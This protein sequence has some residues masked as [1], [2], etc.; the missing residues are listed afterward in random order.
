MTPPRITVILAVWN[1]AA[2]LTRALQSVWEQTYPAVEVVV[3]D[4][5]SA[6][7]TADILRAHTDKI[8]CWESAPDR[9][10]YHAW[11]KALARA[12][13]D[14]I[15]FLGAD[16]RLWSPDALARLAAALPADPTI[17]GPR[18]VYGQA[19]IVGPS[20]T[21]ARLDGRPW[22]QVKRGLPWTLTLPHPG[23]L[24]HRT[25]F[26]ERGLFD[27]TFRIVGDY[28]LLLREL[29]PAGGREALFVPDVVTVG[30]AH[31]GVSHSPRAMASMLAE[32]AR[33]R[34]KHVLRGGWPSKVWWKMWTA[35][36]LFRLVGDGGFRTLADG[37]RRLRGRPPV[38]Q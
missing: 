31:G 24:H 23:A 22:A 36:A 29:G 27:E 32:I 34:K 19:A 9:G 12:T 16:D 10:I 17:A 1:G 11:N 30:F 14:W 3:M 15:A 21:V 8:A 37:L 20:G 7:G 2:T 35:A 6:D 18:V 33:A 25:L 5:G 13:G 38:W 28:E 26:K 4:G